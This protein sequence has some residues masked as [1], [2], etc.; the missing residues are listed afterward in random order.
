MIKKEMLS[1]KKRKKRNAY[2]I[3]LKPFDI[4]CKVMLIS[5][6]EIEEK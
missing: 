5:I 4:L 2:K 6:L 1:K 3:S